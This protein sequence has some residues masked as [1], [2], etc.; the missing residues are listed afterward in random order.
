M[1]ANKGMLEKDRDICSAAI[2]VFESL[3]HSLYD[4]TITPAMLNK[5]EAKLGQVNKIIEAI[6]YTSTANGEKPQSPK[7]VLS[8]RNNEY[9]EF[10]KYREQLQY[11]YLHINDLT[12]KG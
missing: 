8:R 2:G 4:G 5:L 6:D 11:F 10:R 3:L 12:V 7:E 9:K 1:F